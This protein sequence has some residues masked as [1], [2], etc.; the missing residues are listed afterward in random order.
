VQELATARQ[1]GIGLITLL[2]NNRAYGN[3]MRDQRERFGNRLIGAA[4]ANPDFTDLA[5]AFGVKGYRVASPD[6]LA[7]LL[8]NLLGTREPVLVEIEVGEGSETSPWEFIHARL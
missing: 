3:V 7:A 6:E 8:P 5:R 2:F 4:L 1:Y